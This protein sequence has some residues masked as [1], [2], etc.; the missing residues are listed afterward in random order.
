MYL[1][2]Y[3]RNDRKKKNKGEGEM[4]LEEKK[5]LRIGIRESGSRDDIVACAMAARAYV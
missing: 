3:W 5:K 1:L 4:R 2:H